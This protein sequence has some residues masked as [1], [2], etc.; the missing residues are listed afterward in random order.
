MYIA[1]AI[2]AVVLVVALLAYNAN[3]LVYVKSGQYDIDRRI[4]AVTE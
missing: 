3:L 4:D 2:V 1:I